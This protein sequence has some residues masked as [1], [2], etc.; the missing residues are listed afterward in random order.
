LKR[1]LGTAL[2]ALAFI[3]A[4]A[5]ARAANVTLT[6]TGAGSNVVG[7]IYIGPYTATDGTNT[8]PVICDD[9]ADESYLYQP[10]TASVSTFADLTGT[11]WGGQPNAAMLYNEAAWLSDQL[12]N[13]AVSPT[14][15]GALQYAIWDVF[16]PASFTYLQSQ[17]LTQVYN[18]ASNWL[19]QAQTQI[20]TPGEFS[21]YVIYTPTG[22]APTPQE[23]LRRVPEPG[24]LPLMAIALAGLA[25]LAG[26]RRS[27]EA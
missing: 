20:Y 17:G 24:T 2:F 14:T 15:A 16:D 27:S 18:S 26:R 11:K 12:L 6:L 1:F 19:S 7:G 9:F 8:F 25:I 21:D 13:P 23:F 3:G 4:P 22:P 10:W 5:G